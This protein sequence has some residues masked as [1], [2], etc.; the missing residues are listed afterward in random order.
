MSSFPRADRAGPFDGSLPPAAALIEVRDLAVRFGDRTVFDRLTF[1]VAD[2][3]LLCVLGPSGSGKSTLLRVLGGLLQPTAGRVWIAGDDPE[4]S[5]G[6]S[7]F[8]FQSPRLVPWR[9]VRG[10][11]RLAQEL[12]TGR[13]DAGRVEA[14]IG[15]TGL[16]DQAERYPAQLSG[17]ERQR[18][19]LARAL[20]IEPRILFVDEP[21]NALDQGS[22]ERLREELRRIWRREHL[23]VVFVTHDLAEAEAL[24]SRILVLGD[25]RG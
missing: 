19:A 14:M 21:F 1:A 15:L 16:V 2:G 12:R 4:R 24:A 13:S 18:A 22:R 8:V 11:I 7:A 6:R 10:N 25:R 20:V 3:E 5:W 17:G 9:T 23:T